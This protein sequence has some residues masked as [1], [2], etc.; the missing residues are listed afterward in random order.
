MAGSSRVLGIMSGTSLDG[1]DCVL[2]SV[3]AE[4]R[5]SWVRNWSR[6]FPIGLKRRLLACAS[7]ESRSWECGQLHHDLG[8]F[9]ARVAADGLGRESVAAVGL[10]GQTVFHQGSGRV[11]ATWQIGE[12][13]YLAEALR[14]PVVSNFR[15]ADLAAGGEGAPLA[16]LFHVRVF[17]ER[18]RHVCVQNLGGIG[19][20]TSID[21]RV[22]ATPTVR[23]FDTGP[24][25]MLI[26]GAVRRL[27][28]GRLGY[29][30]GGRWASAG[31]V[32]EALVRRWL[33]HPFF[34][35]PPPK[36]TG[37]E[38]FGSAYLDRCWRAMDAAGLGRDDRVACLLELTVRSVVLNYRLHLPSRPDRVMVAGGGALNPVLMS[39][40][41]ATLKV[42]SPGMEILEGATLGWPVEAVEGGAFALLAWERLQGRPGNLPETTG[43]RRAVRC[44]QVTES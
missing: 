34:L 30:R 35:R 5:P 1:V 17:A 27:S 12:P 9:Y 13:S 15:A 32:H 6:R 31:V 16:T 22:G 4:G 29:D 39:R 20:V 14:V 24:G 10:H 7:G 28:E 3:D 38:Q 41:A 42:W 25:N 2:T 33:R 36:S 44:G 43:A 11:P 18:G 40:F 8:R 19:N 37:R 26:D 23:S 21:W